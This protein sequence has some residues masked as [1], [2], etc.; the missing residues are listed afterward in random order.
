MNNPAQIQIFLDSKISMLLV[1]EEIL[2]DWTGNG[3]RQLPVLLGQI[4]LKMGW[5]DKQLR[6]NDPIIREYIRTHADW[7]VTRGAHGGIMRA[8]D[9]QKKTALIEA[10]RQ[11]KEE[12]SIALDAEVAR[13]MAEASA[14]VAI[15]SAVDSDNV[16]AE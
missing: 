2:N 14:Q 3:C 5:S 11:A 13:K 12:I 15:I 6:A 4:Q 1:V 8:A 10:K 16:A 9:K 7:D